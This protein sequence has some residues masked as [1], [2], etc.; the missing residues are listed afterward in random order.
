MRRVLSSCNNDSEVS[1]IFLI[2]EGVG[3]NALK[4]FLTS[5][6]DTRG[7]YGTSKGCSW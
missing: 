5:S 4:F 3:S 7:L 2:L 6:G 1:A